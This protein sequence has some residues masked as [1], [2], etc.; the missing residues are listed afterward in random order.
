MV[1]ED[2][3]PNGKQARVDKLR[4]DL[5]HTYGDDEPNYSGRRNDVSRNKI[6]KR[7]AKLAKKQGRKTGT[8]E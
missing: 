4:L 5:I 6:A 8:E 2:N 3:E 7:M 1:F